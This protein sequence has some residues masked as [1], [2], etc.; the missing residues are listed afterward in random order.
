[1][2]PIVAGFGSVIVLNCWSGV[3]GDLLTCKEDEAGPDVVH[4]GCGWHDYRHLSGV[5]RD[6]IFRNTY[7]G[8]LAG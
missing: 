3:D 1:M 4:A 7:G 6:E 5:F 2:L 8:R